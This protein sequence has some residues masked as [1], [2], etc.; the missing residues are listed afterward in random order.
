MAQT[1]A[2]KHEAASSTYHKYDPNGTAIWA[3]QQIVQ[4]VDLA[5]C[6]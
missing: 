6:V 4:Y 1:P 3:P 5:R 2:N